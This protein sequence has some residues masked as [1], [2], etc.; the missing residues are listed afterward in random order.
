MNKITC[1]CTDCKR[2]FNGRA[3][4]ARSEQSEYISLAVSGMCPHCGEFAIDWKGKI[5]VLPVGA[6]IGVVFDPE[7]EED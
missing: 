2:S 5:S 4:A 6:D 1:Y 7:V 3:A